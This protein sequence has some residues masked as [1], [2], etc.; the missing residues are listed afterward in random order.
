MDDAEILAVQPGETVLP[1]LIGSGC[2][3]NTVVDTGN[4]EATDGNPCQ[5][6]Q[7][8]DL[9]L[10]IAQRL[11]LGFTLPK[12]GGVFPVLIRPEIR[13]LVAAVQLSSA[14]ASAGAQAVAAL[15]RKAPVVTVGV[16]GMQEMRLKA[17]A[18][19]SKRPVDRQLE[20]VLAGSKHLHGHI[21]QL[22]KMEASP[23]RGPCGTRSWCQP[24]AV[25]S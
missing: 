16:N 15:P 5:Q 7:G 23:W 24:T 21:F 17:L 9:Q 19:L 22:V 3:S 18:P 11:D 2:A 10:G 14:G 12:A 25:A 20:L 4:L 13:D 8:N 1:R 6:L